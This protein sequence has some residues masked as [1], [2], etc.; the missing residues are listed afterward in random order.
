MIP[1]FTNTGEP[2]RP[3]AEAL[4]YLFV[5]GRTG[6][7]RARSRFLAALGM[8]TRKAKA[9]AKEEADSLRE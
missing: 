4:G 2:M 1:I 3:K 7:L 6:A 5:A 9:R 8:T